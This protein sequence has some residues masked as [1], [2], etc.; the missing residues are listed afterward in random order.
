MM[1]KHLGKRDGKNLIHIENA[2]GSSAVNLLGRFASSN[3]KVGKIIRDVVEKEQQNNPD[4]ILAEI[5]HLP[6]SRTG[7][8]LMRPVFR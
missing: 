4:V 3:I 2:G 6:E 5:V 1:Y 8:I 7:N